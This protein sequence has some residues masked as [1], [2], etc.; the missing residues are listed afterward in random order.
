MAGIDDEAL[1][2]VVRQAAGE[3]SDADRL[4]FEAWYDSGPRQQ[5]AYLR[6]QAIWHSLDAATTQPN[7]RPQ[8]VKARPVS[9]RV[10]FGGMAAGV[11]AAAVGLVTYNAMKRPAMVFETALGEIRKVPL[12]DSSI[13]TVNS[14]SRMEVAM[15]PSLRR[16]VLVEG[17]ALFEVAKNPNRPFVVEAGDI[18]VRAV[19][20]AFSV[21]RRD[22]GA[23]VLVTEGVVEIS[24]K[25]ITTHR[26]A[27]GNSAVVSAQADVK[28][29]PAEAEIT[30][31]LAWREGRIVLDNQTLAEAVDEFNRYNRVKIAIADPA[32]RGR[33]LVG[34]YRLD[35]PADFAMTVQDLMQ[36]PVTVGPDTIKIGKVPRAL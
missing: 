16:I 3:L 23:D 36:V 17:E 19:G 31:R 6:A 18:R 22:G 21:R 25:G 34:Q 35:Q 33:R 4:A 5:G 27:A 20:T 7:L 15:T 1:E 8:P 26:V 9:R 2:W 10:L 28:V 11:A 30:R 14:A 12:E 24:G 13:A 29:A 32:I